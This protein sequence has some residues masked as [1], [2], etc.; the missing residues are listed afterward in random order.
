MSHKPTISNSNYKNNLY[1]MWW[2]L[3]LIFIKEWRKSIASLW[4]PWADRIPSREETS[5]LSKSLIKLYWSKQSSQFSRNWRYL[6]RIISAMESILLNKKQNFSNSVSPRT[7]SSMGNF[8]SLDT[9]TT[10]RDS[11]FTSKTHSKHSNLRGKWKQRE[12]LSITQSNSTK[13]SA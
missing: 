9:C 3:F 5:K 11:I 6:L 8:T 1:A 2:T 10:S 13:I 4:P 7:V 12:T